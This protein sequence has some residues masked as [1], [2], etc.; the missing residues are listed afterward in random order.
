MNSTRR[1]FRFTTP[2][3]IRSTGEVVNG[4]YRAAVGRLSSAMVLATFTTTVS[5]VFGGV[6]ASH[7]RVRHSVSSSQPVKSRRYVPR[8]AVKLR[9]W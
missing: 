2:C 9:S 6:V 4:P 7:E 1:Y 5:V 3:P 8:G